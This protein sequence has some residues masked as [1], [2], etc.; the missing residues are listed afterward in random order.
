MSKCAR[1]IV[2]PG[3]SERWLQGELGLC[4]LQLREGSPGACSVLVN[5]AAVWGWAYSLREFITIRIEIGGWLGSSVVRGGADST[6]VACWIPFPAGATVSCAL[7][8]KKPTTTTK[9]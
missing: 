1:G 8:E 3:G 9:N 7:F 2:H 6:N 4:P 5:S